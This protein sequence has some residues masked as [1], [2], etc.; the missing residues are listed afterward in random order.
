MKNKTCG[1]CKCYQKKQSF[2]CIAVTP[3]H[4]ACEEFEPKEAK[5]EK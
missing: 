5:D 4:E 3:D 2:W 1:D